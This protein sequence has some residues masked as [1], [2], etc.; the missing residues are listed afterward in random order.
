MKIIAFWYI[1]PC[2][3][4]EAGRRFRGAYCLC[5]Q[6]DDE[7]MFVHK[8]IYSYV[9]HTKLVSLKSVQPFIFSIMLNFLLL[10]PVHCGLWIQ[11]VSVIII[12]IIIIILIIS[13]TTAL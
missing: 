2:R 4:V 7:K 10:H 12:I 1:A 9:L 8:L 6:G 13:G 5:Y 3:L 11:Y